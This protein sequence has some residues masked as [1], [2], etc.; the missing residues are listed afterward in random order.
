VLHP[1]SCWNAVEAT[2]DGV[3]VTTPQGVDE[4]D[5]VIV[6]TGFITD[7]SLRP[8]LAELHE[9]VALWRDRYQPPE[10]ERHDDLARHPYLGPSFEFLP[11]QA[12]AHDWVSHVYN[13]TFGCLL[14][15]GFGGASISGMKYSLPRLV[16]GITRSLFVEDREHHYATLCGWN[17]AE[18]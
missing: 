3:R 18:F 14:S 10:Q 17:V 13:Y 7:L 16:G 9:H 6:G 8:E 1:N 2:A 5:F 4:L 15:L 12:G 11:R